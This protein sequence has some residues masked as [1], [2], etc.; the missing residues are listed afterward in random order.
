VPGRCPAGPA[1]W[2]GASFFIGQSDLLQRVVDRRQSAVQPDGRTQFVQGKVGLLTQQR[3]HLA[4]MGRQDPRLA[5]RSMMARPDIAGSP[6]LLQKLL[7]HAQRDTKALRYLCSCALLPVVGSK[8]PFTQI[9]RDRSH[10]RSLSQLSQ[11]GY[12]FI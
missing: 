6:A 7:H 11:N 9:Q 10:E 5:S 4:M 8:D 2:P 12:S 1:H 3:A